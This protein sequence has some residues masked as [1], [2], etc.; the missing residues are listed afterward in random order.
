MYRP[1]SNILY[2]LLTAGFQHL[3]AGTHGGIEN[4]MRLFWRGHYS[5]T[6]SAASGSDPTC[7]GVDEA[8]VGEWG[9][10][11]QPARQKTDSCQMAFSAFWR[12]AKG[13]VFK[14]R[15]L[16]A[17]CCSYREAYYLVSFWSVRSFKMSH[18]S[19]GTDKTQNKMLSTH[20]TWIS[21]TGILKGC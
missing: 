3:C 4:L 7:A 19:S 2:I 1:Q 9:E 6:V 14:E 21:Y 10:L 15:G 17:V 13:L 18:C 20:V 5:I 8:W 16:T 11:A 12:W